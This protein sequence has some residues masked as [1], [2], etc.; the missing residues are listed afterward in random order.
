MPTRVRLLLCLFLLILLAWIVRR[1]TS[2]F[3]C[4]QPVFHAWDL[5]YWLHAP[6]YIEC[7]GAAA[8]ERV[9]PAVRATTAS[10]LSAVDRQR[11]GHFVRREYLQNGDNRFCPS[12]EH[13]WPYF[14][15]HARPAHV[16]LYEA[17]LAPRP[18]RTF[19]ETET[20]L[21]P[22][23]GLAE[24]RGMIT[25]R[26]LDVWL[27]RDDA[28]TGAQYVDYLCV[29]ELHRGRGV[30][31]ALIHALWRQH[32]EGSV[33]LFK[34]EDTLLPWVVPWV[35]YSTYGFRAPPS[36]PA[37]R[38]LSPATYTLAPV[39]AR[40]VREF[41]SFV[42]RRT[43]E[44]MD[45]AVEPGAANWLELLRTGNLFAWVLCTVDP[46][47]HIVV[48][49]FVYRR[50][51]IELSHGQSV[52]GC[53]ASLRACDAAVFDEAFLTSA[54]D[55]ARAT[56]TTCLAVEDVAD[57]DRLI[58]LLPGP[59]LVVSPTAYYWHRYAM[60]PVSPRRT[61]VVA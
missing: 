23:R 49:C 34:R 5:S 55:T 6:G 16:C 24:L 20:V 27:R 33:S 19:P 30:A 1:A 54:A 35:T 15:G 11:M 4:R 57:N 36:A 14:V 53:V 28:L 46:T 29:A 50:T 37:P 43:R 45:V 31:P 40:N 48:A 42:A 38:F 17:P 2:G 52:L 41:R 56:G 51:C 3:W 7:A 25:S 59:P 44:T 18:R 32:P 47:A 12:D 26:P 9:H 39:T 21:P 13:W 10:A 60:H 58:D 61:W 22:C 8:N